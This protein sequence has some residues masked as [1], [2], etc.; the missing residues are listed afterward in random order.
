MVKNTKIVVGNNMDKIVGSKTIVYEEVGS[1]N[2][3]AKELLKTQNVQDGTIIIANAQTAGKGRIGRDWSSPKD[4]GIFMSIIV[5][6]KLAINQIPKLTL[7]SGLAMC[8]ALK[9]VCNQNNIYIKWPNDIIINDKKI[10]GILCELV[11]N[12]TGQNFVII[13][14]GV[15]VNQESFSN[16]LPYASSLYIEYG[17]KFSRETIINEFENIFDKMYR[18]YLREKNLSPFIDEY[19]KV[20]I[21]TGKEVYVKKNEE[22]EKVTV[23]RIN[24][25]GALEVID[26]EGNLKEIQSGEVS[27]RGLYGYV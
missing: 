16:D 24:E 7:I 18:T 26:Q 2:Q 19:V 22:L 27:I 21:N 5:A 9:K 3:I 1:T 8:N 17:Q 14:I 23:S 12:N 6:P 10:C 15:N 4:V 13:G 11:G 20:C 25:E